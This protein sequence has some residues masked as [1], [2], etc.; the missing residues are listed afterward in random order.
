MMD[1]YK[2][3]Q[4]TYTDK[5]TAKRRTSAVWN[6]RFRDHLRRRQRLAGELDKRDTLRMAERLRD[7]VRSRRECAALPPELSKWLESLPAAT[8][9]RLT[10]MD[11]IDATTAA[12]ER[13]LIE[14]LE[15]RK[16]AAGN[17]IE[18]GYMQAILARGRTERH[19]RTTVKRVRAVLDGCAFTFWRNLAAPGAATRIECWLADR[20]RKG[21]IGGT[22]FNY[23]VRDMRGFCNWLSEQ[24]RVPGLALQ[25]LGRVDN[26][27]VDADPRRALSVDELR[28]LIKAAP[29][30][31]RAGLTRDE[32]TLLYRFA[33]ETGIRP[34]EIRQLR[35]GA[36]QLD[37]E[38]PTVTAAAAT[39]KRRKIHIQVL[40]PEMAAELKQR[41]AS[42]MAAAIA[43]KM[44]SE[45][46]QSEMLRDDLADARKAWISEA[47]EGPARDE[48]I[49]S[50][51]LATVNHAGERAVFYSCRHAHGTA[52]AE[53]GVPEKDIALSMHHASRATTARYLHSDRT[54]VSLAIG[55]LPE[56]AE[57]MRQIATGTADGPKESTEVIISALTCAKLVQREPWPNDPNGLNRHFRPGADLAGNIDKTSDS[58]IL[59]ENEY[60][61]LLAE[62]ADAV[63]SKS[64]ARKGISVRL[65]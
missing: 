28:W 60:H 6:I 1:E 41:F 22:S 37:A 33:F 44:G 55:R 20:R 43:F 48:R 18:P 63:D 17:I 56:I 53:V 47:P 31:K 45:Y 11:L 42:K 2:L 62:L 61:G 13:P 27:D 54:A 19:A 30:R 35:V 15:G 25:A 7:L 5:K 16:D 36:F 26:A 59:P 50:D 34:G 32:R 29:D 9:K 24:C 58:A 10:E 12:S 8:R 23:Y 51:F 46:H 14:H 52:L 4:P 39:N 21:E 57:P 40:R 49:K 3:F 38:R 64:T 65:R